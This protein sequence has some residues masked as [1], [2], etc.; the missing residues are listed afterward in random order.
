[1]KKSKKIKRNN[2]NSSKKSK[3][4]TISPPSKDFNKT[5]LFLGLILLIG[6]IIGLI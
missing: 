5:L 1:M 4:S 2:L 6:A 3:S